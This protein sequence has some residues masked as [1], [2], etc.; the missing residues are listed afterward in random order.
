MAGVLKSR[1]SLSPSVAPRIFGTSVGKFYHVTLLAPRI[2]RWLVYVWE[3][4]TPLVYRGI[5]N[6]GHRYL[7]KSFNSV[8]LTSL[9]VVI[10]RHF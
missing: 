7:G 9:T 6:L 3:I 8:S 1:G 5:S 4:C 10:R 2:L